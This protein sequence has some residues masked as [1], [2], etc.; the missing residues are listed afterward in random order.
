[1]SALSALIIGKVLLL[2]RVFLSRDEP[3]SILLEIGDLTNMRKMSERIRGR[4]RKDRP[5]TTISI[6]VPEDVIDDLKEIAPSSGI[7]PGISL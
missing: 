2:S 5:M 7:S 4:L 1:V 6:R 3:R